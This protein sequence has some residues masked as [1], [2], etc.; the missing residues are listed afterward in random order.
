MSW[1]P[2]PSLFIMMHEPPAFVYGDG[3]VKY[4]FH[5]HYARGAT[6]LGMAQLKQ[7]GQRFISPILFVDGHAGKHDFTK[8]IKAT[9]PRQ[10]RPIRCTRWNPLRIGFGISRKTS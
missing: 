1:A 4:L 2:N 10:S 9:S 5:W 3:G 7:D 8:A 6:T